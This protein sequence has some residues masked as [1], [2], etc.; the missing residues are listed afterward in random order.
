MPS[1]NE[2]S[3]TSNRR[4]YRQQT[5]QLIQE[6]DRLFKS[7]RAKFPSKVNRAN[8]EKF[9]PRARNVILRDVANLIWKIHVDEQAS[10]HGSFLPLDAF[11]FATE[12]F[13]IDNDESL[14]DTLKK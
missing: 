5:T 12:S 11:R 7:V 2:I 13:F 9:K 3:S 8:S 1:R 10:L 4:S 14:L 6:L